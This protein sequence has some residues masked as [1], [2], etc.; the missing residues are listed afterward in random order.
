MSAQHWTF[1]A[2]AYGVTF[3]VVGA[4]AA[5]IVFEHRRLRAELARLDA[6]AVKDSG[7]GA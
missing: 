6:L 3:L 4:V 1:V 7:G 5:R 2:L